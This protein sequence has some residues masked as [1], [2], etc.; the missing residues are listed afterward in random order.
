VISRRIPA[1]TVLLGVELTGLLAAALALAIAAAALPDAGAIAWS[2]GA[3]IAGAVGLVLLFRA[4]AVGQIS[5]VAP[6]SA[7][8]AGLPVIVG[9]A[10]GE[11]PG[12][13]PL[14]GIAL[15]LIG[16][17]LVSREPG[18]GTSPSSHRASIA[19]ALLATLGIGAYLT[20]MHYA[21]D[22]NSIWWPLLFARI[23]SVS[24]GLIALCGGAATIP[25]AG[26]GGI[27]FVGLTD[28]GGSLTYAAAT[29]GGRLLALAAVLASLYP[30]VS[31]LLA[32]VSL[33]EHLLGTQIAGVTVALLGV[34]MMATY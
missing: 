9:L 25:R 26:L 27:A 15:G 14:A 2:V 3:G 8:G 12:A 6:I 19:L 10:G 4:M 11:R 28:F 18:V 29:S 22:H 23:G 1:F 30:I 16:C 17:L 5:I 20:G 32:R 21:T 13:V 7:C 31:V 34:C 33:D 24:V